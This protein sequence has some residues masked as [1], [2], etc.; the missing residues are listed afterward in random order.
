MLQVDK[1]KDGNTL[2]MS[3]TGKLDPISAPELKEVFE[4]AMV[5][6]EKLIL[7]LQELEYTSSAGLRVILEMYKTMADKEGML[8]RNVNETVMKVFDSVGF[9]RFLEIE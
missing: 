4:N 8:V 6:V 7:D 2:I 1:Q 3:L 5:D 9:S